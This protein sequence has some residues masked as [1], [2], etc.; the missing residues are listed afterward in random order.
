MPTTPVATARDRRFFPLDCKLKLRADHWSEGAARVATRQGLQ[1]KSFDLAA[2]AYSEAVGGT[3][4]ADSLQRITEGWG[5]QVEAQRE[6][7]AERANAPAQKGESPRT[8]RLPENDPLPEQA[9][10]S[11]DG[12]MI[13][14]CGEGWKEVKLTAIS[15]V[16]VKQAG[17]CA[18]QQARPSRR[19]HDPLVEL[20]RHSYQAGLWDADTMGQHQYAEGLRRGLERC[21]RLSSVNDGAEWIERITR[22]N[23]ARAVQIVDWSHASGRLW[24]VGKAVFGEGSTEAQSWVEARLDVL[25]DGQVGNVVMAL[26]ALAPKSEQ[27]AEVVRQGAGYF[28]NNEARMHYAEYRAAGYPIGS[29]TVESAANTLVHHRMRR[30][31]RGWKRN[32]AQAMLAGLSELHSGR[33]AH[34]WEA[35]LP[36][37][38]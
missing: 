36:T 4:S 22:T 18:V 13:L 15:A 9:N 3:M 19:E 7:E 29:G 32:N 2:E 11:T 21:Q 26:E 27:A 20:S 16:T 24:D 33:F 17:A 35:T 28:R 38:I 25:W 34:A 31:G 23:F 14:V 37:A 8:Q 1:A 10:L 6:S 30:P 5:A 12:A